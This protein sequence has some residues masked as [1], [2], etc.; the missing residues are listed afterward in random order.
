MSKES[1]QVKDIVLPHFPFGTI[2]TIFVVLVL[3]VAAFTCFYTVQP[4]EV[5]VVTRLGK[6]I[7]PPA[8]PGL[9]FKLPFGIDRVRLV[10]VQRQEQQA[11]GFRTAQAGVRSE[12]ITS[13]ER[14]DLLNEALMVTGDLNA[15]VVEWVVQ[16]RIVGP[17]AYLFNVRHPEETLRD[18]SEAVMR[19]VIGDHTVDEVLTVGR[20]EIADSVLKKLQTRMDEYEMGLRIEQVVLQDANPPDPVKNSFNEVNQAQQ[21]RERLINEARAA[22]NKV[23]PRARGQA[24]QRIQAA[25]GYALERVNEAEGNAA[26]F[27]A[28]YKAYIKAPEATRRRIYLETMNKVISASGR[29]FILDEGTQGVLPLL[30]LQQEEGSQ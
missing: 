7:E 9:H 5:G 2:L 4:D 28:V 20:Q 3:L 10:T 15:A 19:Q 18:A 22:Y 6:Y 21:E 27:D 14:S 24:A 12:F 13:N 25:E 30:Q 8:Q 23:I 26:K 29:K 1:F 11:F 16:Y 17:E